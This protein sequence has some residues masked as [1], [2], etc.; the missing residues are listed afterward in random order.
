[1][2]AKATAAFVPIAVPCRCRYSLFVN[3]KE[4]SSRMS[5]VGIASCHM[6]WSTK[7]SVLKC[8][9]LSTSFQTDHKITL[10]CSQTKLAIMKQ[11]STTDNAAERVE[12]T[13]RRDS[14]SYV[15]SFRA[16][17]KLPILP[18]RFKAELVVLQ[19]ALEMTAKSLQV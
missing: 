8:D 3:L 10:N 16:W 2:F 19:T 17:R 12:S 7:H 14:V 11:K 5:L 15:R 1:M 9:L 4:F 6:P 13:K 18:R